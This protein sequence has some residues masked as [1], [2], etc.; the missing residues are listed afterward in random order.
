MFSRGRKNKN[1]K[2]I[3]FNKARS[4]SKKEENYRWL[5]S[6]YRA[7]FYFLATAFFLVVFYAV[8]FSQFLAVEKV[9]LVGVEKLDFSA[10][11]KAAENAYVGKY[12]GFIPKN[13]F[14]LFPKKAI[15]KKLKNEFKRIGEIK[16]NKRFP[17]SVEIKVTEREALLLW[18]DNSG[19]CFIVDENGYAYQ[20]VSMDSKEVLENDLV[21]IS[22]QEDRKVFEGEKIISKEKTEF[23]LGVKNIIRDK[24]SVEFTGEARVKSRV[25]EEVILESSEGWEIYASTAFP[26]EKAVKMLG[27]FLQKQITQQDRANLE[28]VDLRVENRIYYKLKKEEEKENENDKEVENSE[29]PVE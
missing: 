28:Y 23:L 3:E 22:S 5:R 7:F 12:F 6:A 20:S 29:K 24:S 21:K 16:I 19:E 4:I 9:S 18:C 1:K 17:Q 26:L 15:E 27:L 25:A 14:L 8:F 2:E 11:S 13:N 10:V